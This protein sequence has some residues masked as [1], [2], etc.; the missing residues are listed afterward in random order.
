MRR[1]KSYNIN[2]PAEAAQISGARGT[3]AMLSYL[4]Q[5]LRVGWGTARVAVGMALGQ[6]IFDET[7]QL[8]AAPLGVGAAG[9]PA[10]LG[11]EAED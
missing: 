4:Q 11:P 10:V 5:R 3:A 2:P 9:T 8:L 7:R 6:L 1:L